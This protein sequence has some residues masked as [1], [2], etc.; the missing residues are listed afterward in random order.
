MLRKT[1][2]RISDG[3][4]TG[5]KRQQR[6]ARRRVYRQALAQALVRLWPQLGQEAQQ[7]LARRHALM[8]VCTDLNEVRAWRD[9]L[10]EKFPPSHKSQLPQS[11]KLTAFVRWLPSPSGPEVAALIIDG[12]PASVDQSYLLAHELAHIVIRR[13]ERPIH[14]TSEWKAAWETEKW[15]LRGLFPDRAIT[16]DVA[17][18]VK[19]SLAWALA[20]AWL[21]PSGMRHLPKMQAFLRHQGLITRQ[22]RLG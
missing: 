10:D 8:I 11:G 14:K 5:T 6:E 20:V 12:P 13:E 7:Q 15:R 2:E 18:S 19:E 9:F 16:E 21:N 17:N 4:G 1:W 3:L 22:D